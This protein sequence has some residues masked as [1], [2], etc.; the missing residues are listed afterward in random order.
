MMIVFCL[1]L[2][3][4][5]TQC[6]ATK[7]RKGNLLTNLN[8]VLILKDSISGELDLDVQTDKKSKQ[9]ATHDRIIKFCV[10]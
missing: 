2:R 6:N 10:A 1:H 5:Y 3:M 8:L 9:Q 4:L 7:I